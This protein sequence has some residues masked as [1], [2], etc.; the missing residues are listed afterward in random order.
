VGD[1]LTP[2]DVVSFSAAY[3]WWLQQ[4]SSTNKV[5]IG[6]DTRIS[7][8]IVQE[9]IMTTLQLSGIDVLDAGLSTTPSIEL[10]VTREQACGGIIVSASHNGMEWNA[11]KF[12]NEKG[13]FISESAGASILDAAANL[14]LDF[15]D[16]ESLGHRSELSD[17]IEQHIDSILK[18]PDVK[19]NEVRNRGFRV[20]V[21]CINST[22]SISIVPLLR[23]LGCEVVPLHDDMSGRFA[24]DP[25]PLESNLADLIK[26]VKDKDCDL[27]LAVDPDVDRLA[28][29]SEDGS[30]FGEEYTIV[31]LADYLLAERGG[32]T[33][34][35]LSSTQALRDVTEKHG[36]TYVA[37]SVGEVNVVEKMKEVQAVFGGEGNGGVIYPALHYGRDALVGVA[38]F[39]SH[40]CR[41]N[42]T[43]SQLRQ[44]YP[45]YHISK[46]KI[47]LSNEMDPDQ[48]IK[49]ISDQYPQQEKIAIDGLKLI[50]DNEWVHLR[51]SNTEPIIRVYA[52]S[53]DEA[54]ASRLANQFI[55]NIQTCLDQ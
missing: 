28:F 49:M 47:Q 5:V 51:K 54:R 50:F 36:G 35:N 33:V 16:I 6:R 2:L 37:S 21:D 14:D 8:P 12:L 40:L 25:E 23:K 45:D 46:K 30:F 15:A 24:H 27:G 9:L 17:V 19:N 13:E 18:L 55:Q 42:Q 44:T 20:A 32:Y 52:E 26:V 7:G 4:N 3:A 53:S 39:L 41:S 29:V 31:A 48:I 10:A 34:S 38:L 11:L 1:S 43:P 22:G